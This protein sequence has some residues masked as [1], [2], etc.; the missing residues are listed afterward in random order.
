M[1]RPSQ[2]VNVRERPSAER[3]GER[4]PGRP[5]GRDER[6]SEGRGEGRGNVAALAFVVLALAA[7]GVLYWKS[8][9]P[10]GE[11]G[12]AASA[13]ASATAAAPAEARCK[14][15]GDE[16]VVG[17]ASTA[18]ALGEG[19]APDAGD[20]PDDDP[21]A[22]FAAEVGRGVTF[23]RGFAAGVRQDAEGGAVAV[24]ATL[25]LDGGASGEKGKLVKLGRTRGD[26]DPPV[27]AASGASLYAALLEPAANG[28]LVRLAR[29]RGEQ[30]TWGLTEQ[31]GDDDES[32]ALDVAASGA[33]GIVVWD[34]LGGASPDDER[35]FVAASVFDL[36][37]LKPIGP[38]LRLSPEGVDA[39]LPKVVARPGG[40]WVA[41]VAHGAGAPKPESEPPRDAKPEKPE[42]PG[43]PGKPGKPAKKPGGGA[44]EPARGEERGE[45]QEERGGELI[46]DRW[47][48]VMPLDERG[49]ALGAPRA[50][51][52]KDGRVL[53]FDLELGDDGALLVAYRDDD[54][55]S[56]SHGGK[57][58]LATAKLAALS[59]PRLLTDEDV[60][61]GVP[62]LLPGWLAV[63]S[64]TTAPRLA[65][66][67]GAG[68]LVGELA[69]EPSL[70]RLEVLSAKG[71]HLFVAK[72]QGK[73]VRLGVRVCR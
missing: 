67:D 52:P 69:P 48:E 22:P 43:K 61:A 47:I 35:S 4:G 62:D 51:T 9:A 32:L 53:A 7:S 63:P 57:L 30:V 17:D 49:V 36:E 28:R 14:V 13:T 19:L 64:L 23:D 1:A 58:A 25:P 37:S 3:P 38:K 34:D 56:G 33:H 55:P 68:N 26:F 60:G 54:T 29:V 72:P 20:E 42:K 40:Y 31:E 59:E 46:T 73:A 15:L 39:D 71:D 44:A 18:R 5:P 16:L 27:L 6:P 24:V 41:Y 11:A 21:F 65:R 8:R 70:K 66:I 50:L 45:V 12:A 2:S 10:A